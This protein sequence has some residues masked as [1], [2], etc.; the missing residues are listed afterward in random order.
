MNNTK[1]IIQIIHEHFWRDLRMGAILVVF[2][3]MV[4]KNEKCVQLD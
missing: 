1:W 3:K 4:P 2:I